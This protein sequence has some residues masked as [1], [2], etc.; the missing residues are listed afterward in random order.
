MKLP[1]RLQFIAI[2]VIS[3]LAAYIALPIPNKPGLPFRIHPGRDLAGGAELR[4]R[5]LFDSS[6]SGDRP[7]ATREAVDVLRRRIESKQMK[8]AKI[9]SQGVDGIV[10]QLPGVDADE[11]REY[12]RLIE[13]VGKLELYAAASRDLQERYEREQVVP[14]GFKVFRKGFPAPILVEVPPV[15]E[16]RHIVAA[17]PEQEDGLEGVRWVTRFE[18]DREGAQRF[19]QAAEKLYGQQPRGRIVIV[20]DDVV[21]S[22]PLVNSPAFHG[23]GRITSGADEPK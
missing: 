11:L 23:R 14:P 10:I 16:G 7:K 6:F 4:Y 3:M 17:E 5:M 2:F 8:E 13:S 1:L 20:L 12:K 15:I 18:L 9:T 22:A 19:D 21:R